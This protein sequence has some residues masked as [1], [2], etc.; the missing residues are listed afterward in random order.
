MNSSSFFVISTV[1]FL[2]GCGVRTPG[3]QIQH[4]DARYGSELLP[5]LCDIETGV[6]GEEVEEYFRTRNISYDREDDDYAYR[7]AG[8]PRPGESVRAELVRFQQQTGLSLVSFGWG[9]DVALFDK[10]TLIHINRLSAGARDHFGRRHR[11]HSQPLQ[12]KCI[13]FSRTS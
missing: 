12:P 7:F 10:R 11:D 1:C 5:Y 6:G 13:R 3:E 2:L 4:D 9:L 8:Q